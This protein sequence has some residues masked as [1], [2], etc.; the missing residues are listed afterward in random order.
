[1]KELKINQYIFCT[2]FLIAIF[3][4]ADS[5]SQNKQNFPIANVLR[6]FE[7]ID[8]FPLIIYHL[9]KRGYSEEEIEKVLGLNYISFFKRVVA[10]TY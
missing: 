5:Y 2:V 4:M 3:K 6:V 1:M 10:K 8:G 9:L 7:I